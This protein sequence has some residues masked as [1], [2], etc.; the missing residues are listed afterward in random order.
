MMQRAFFSA[1]A[2]IL[3]S[4]VLVQTAAAYTIPV[5]T[6]AATVTGTYNPLDLNLDTLVAGPNNTLDY[7]GG[8]L[9]FQVDL[10]GTYTNS[11]NAVIGQAGT[12]RLVLS[13]T[14]D[15]TGVY[16]S[17]TANLISMYSNV[18]NRQVGTLTYLTGGDFLPIAG[19]PEDTPL[20]G[21]VFRLFSTLEGLVL[22]VACHDGVAT[23]NDFD[24]TL[25]QDLAHI[26]PY[27]DDG[28]L[29]DTHLVRERLNDS[30]VSGNNV[31]P[32]GSVTGLTASSVPE[33]AT[34]A[35]LGLGLAGLGLSRRP[36][37]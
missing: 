7:T 28:G 31:V 9:F 11:Y 32:C 21:D 34:L 18:S 24:L 25:Q 36:R 19:H 37:A 30:C 6:A 26:G 35:L 20:D 12:W 15:P 27:Q 10:T 13:E 17:D 14:F 2:A 8:S 33:P 4:A 3:L 5:R 29:S 23:C 22:D 16:S 1:F